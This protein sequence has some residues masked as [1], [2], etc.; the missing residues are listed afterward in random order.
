MAPLH[1]LALKESSNFCLSR[2]AGIL[3]YG[4]IATGNH[5]NCGFAA[6]SATPPLFLIFT[7]FI[8]TVSA[9]RSIHLVGAIHESPLL[10]SLRICRDRQKISRI[11][12]PGRFLNRPYAKER[13]IYCETLPFLN[14]PNAQ[15]GSYDGFETLSATPHKR[16]DRGM[17]G[18]KVLSYSS[19]YSVSILQPSM[20]FPR[21]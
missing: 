20:V 4:R 6:Q 15:P 9:L 14:H 16:G 1:P 18:G 12:P 2:R 8:D 21:V 13:L 11:L 19:A 17:T 3:N 7:R 10:G 5:G